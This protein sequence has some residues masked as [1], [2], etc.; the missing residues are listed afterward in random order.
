MDSLSSTIAS[1][2]ATLASAA[3]H[4]A[5]IDTLVGALPVAEAGLP[6]TEGGRSIEWYAEQ[7]P[8]PAPIQAQQTLGI[9]I[10]ATLG[11]AEVNAEHYLLGK[12]LYE[13]PKHL[14]EAQDA[15]YAAWHISWAAVNNAPYGCKGLARRLTDVT[16]QK[17]KTASK[18][19]TTAKALVQRYQD[20]Y[21]GAWLSTPA[22]NADGKWV[23]TSPHFIYRFYVFE[24]VNGAAGVYEATWKPIGLLNPHAYIGSKVLGE[25]KTFLDFVDASQP[26]PDVSAY[27]CKEFG[28]EEED[29]ESLPP[30]DEQEAP[31]TLSRQDAVC[32]GA[33][34]G[35]GV[36]YEETL[37]DLMNDK[38]YSDRFRELHTGTWTTL[39]DGRRA[40]VYRFY[41][42]EPPAD[43]SFRTAQ[44][45]T[46]I[47][48][49]NPDS[50]TVDSTKNTI[51][52]RLPDEQADWPW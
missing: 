35:G 14:L 28:V 36:T 12:S 37:S 10:P 29:N 46:C 52:M 49:Y 44:P 1:L 48:L 24:E 38:Q 17:V 11:N 8:M 41:A 26:A 19:V 42:Y 23:G 7:L 40:M 21:D 32:C 30:C 15:A 47:G 2:R 39:S 31:P 5:Q 4:A 9:A 27:W 50:R 25:G 18:A 22:F 13:C 33:G 6:P 51:R 3:A 34:A 43:G 20:Y 45:L 16:L